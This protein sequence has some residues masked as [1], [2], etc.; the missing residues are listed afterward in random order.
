M[1]TPS[2]LGPSTSGSYSMFLDLSSVGIST[3]ED[4]GSMCLVE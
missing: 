1:F 3:G 2:Q 4:V